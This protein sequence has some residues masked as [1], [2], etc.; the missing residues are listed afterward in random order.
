MLFQI[1]LMLIMFEDYSI[2]IGPFIDTLQL[3]HEF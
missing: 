1:N 2:S 3:L